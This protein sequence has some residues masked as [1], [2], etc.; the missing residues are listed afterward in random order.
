[1]PFSLTTAPGVFQELMAR[2]LESLDKFTVAYPDGILIFFK[3]LEE[4]LA[5]IRNM[6]D[7]L[8]KRRLKLKLKKCSFPK[9]ETKYLGF[10]INEYG[11]KPEQER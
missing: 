1:M 8:R 5:L 9:A 2:V 6:F 3:T 7:R 4:H 11:I 10:V